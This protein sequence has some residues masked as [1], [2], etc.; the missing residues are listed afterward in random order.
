LIVLGITAYNE[1]ASIAKVIIQSRKFADKIIVC[2]DGSEDLTGRIAENLGAE[3]IT[4]QKNLGY[5]IGIRD[6][7]DGAKRAGADVLVTID[8]DGQHDPTEIP[9][10]I[11][12]VLAGEADIAV[13]YRPSRPAGMTRRRRVA[14]R[15]LDVLTGVKENGVYV[16]SQ[17]GFRAYSRRTLSL[18]V[19]E[20]GMGAESEI[21]LKAKRAGL[22]IRQVP[23]HM[24]Y[25]AEPSVDRSAV[26]FSDVI[27]AIVKLSLV[28]R[29][30]R[31]VGLP[32]LVLLLVGVLGWLDVLA[33]Y[34][35]TQGFAIGHAL[36]Y[37]VILLTGMLM[38]LVAMLLF[39]AKMM[40][41]EAR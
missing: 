10:L 3:V 26:H 9:N 30:V 15:A 29:P 4:H 33:T 24:R 22:K 17:S 35:T 5:G 7:V 27:S 28:R 23:V 1:E 16:D 6:V 34:N 39:V 32:G 18:G 20:W 21:L 12:P 2:D 41:E 37:T 31:T 19:S 11:S 25:G 36:V 38:T 8:A 40:L 14:Q 13:G